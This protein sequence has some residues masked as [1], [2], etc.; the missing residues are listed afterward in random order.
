M[1]V[2]N[3][4]WC[5]I[6]KFNLDYY[7][8]SLSLFLKLNQSKNYLRL[9]RAAK[10]DRTR[11]VILCIKTYA[12]N[13]VCQSC[14]KWWQEDE[15]PRNLGWKGSLSERLKNCVIFQL[16]GFERSSVKAYREYRG[17][18]WGRRVFTENIGRIRRL[19]ITGWPSSGRIESPNWTKAELNPN[20][21]TLSSLEVHLIFDWPTCRILHGYFK[22]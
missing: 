21:S 5:L 9:N 2:K 14:L 22:I 15:R 17:S 18:L 6:F 7:F 4:H 13:L 16:I 8:S 19:R 3:K 10:Y 12:S 20:F 1:K 11:E